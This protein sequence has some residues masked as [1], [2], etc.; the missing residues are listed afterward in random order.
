MPH[1]VE[2]LQRASYQQAL[3]YLREAHDYLVRRAYDGAAPIAPG[4]T[5]GVESKRIS[6]SLEAENKPRS[7][8]KSRE[9]MAEVIN[10]AATLERLLGGLVWLT[11][12]FPGGSV[13]TCHPST[14]DAEGSCDLIL[15]SVEN[16]ELARAEVSDVVATAQ[17][18][19]Q[20][21]RKDLRCLGCTVPMLEDRVAR[22]L[23]TASGFGEYLVRE[24]RMWSNKTYHYQLHRAGDSAGTVL[25]EVL[26]RISNPAVQGARR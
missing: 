12:R 5:W 10:M 18:S 7:I 9:A 24:G 3:Q 25:L 21:E 8:G 17:D 4:P 1:L 20:K 15:V 11:H 26:G 16:H 23:I 22:F 13:K 14:S 2:P 6:V 19:N